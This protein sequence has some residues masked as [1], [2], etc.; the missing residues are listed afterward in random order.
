MKKRLLAAFTAAILCIALGA[1]T[2]NEAEK[3]AGG[4][5][6]PNAAST[7][8]TTTTAPSGDVQSTVSE[9]PGTSDAAAVKTTGTSAAPQAEIPQYAV[10]QVS[11]IP[12][13][14]AVAFTQGR[15][16]GTFSHTESKANITILKTVGD[17]EAAYNSEK[18]TYEKSTTKTDI[19]NFP[20]C[21]NDTFFKNKALVLVAHYESAGNIRWEVTGL[22]VKDS[23]LYIRYRRRTVGEGGTAAL[24][25][26]HD[27]ITVDKSAMDGVKEIAYC[28]EEE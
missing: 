10:S 12:A 21:Y 1:C 5:T 25:P 9:Q 24:V 22:T 6:E 23:T 26:F 17:F 15:V 18:S 28:V 3:P 19:N 27:F 2:K 11:S 7:T 16:Q 13:G 14:T 8:T 20:A 4:K